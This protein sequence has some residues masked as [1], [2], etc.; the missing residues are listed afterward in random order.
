VRR[1]CEQLVNDYVRTATSAEVTDLKKAASQLLNQAK[2][3][4]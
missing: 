4:R 1:N 3:L 2:Q